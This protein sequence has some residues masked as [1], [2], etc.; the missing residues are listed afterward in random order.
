[1]DQ[2]L[3]YAANSADVSSQVLQLKQE[4]PDVVIF[5][6]YTSD[7]ILY[8]RTMQSQG[9]K[10]TILIGDDSGFSDPSYIQ[11]VGDIAQGVINRSAFD[12]SQ[13]GSNSAKVNALFKERP[14]AT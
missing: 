5:I 10:P 2:Q 13:E 11:T 14:A 12:A 3:P 7:A 8:T 9:Y 6:S 1:M 4:N